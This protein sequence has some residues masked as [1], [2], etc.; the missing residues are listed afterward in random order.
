VAIYFAWSYYSSGVEV[1]KQLVAIRQQGQP[2]SLGELARRPAV[3]SKLDAQTYLAEVDFDLQSLEA[4]LRPLTK[5]LHAQPILDEK[6]TAAIEQIFSH[7][8]KVL[9]QLQ[10]ASMCENYYSRAD[11]SRSPSEFLE[12]LYKDLPR[13]KSVGRVLTANVK[14]LIAR[15]QFDQAAKQSL[16]IL[17]LAK[18]MDAEPTISA[19]GIAMAVRGLALSSL[20]DTMQS[21][22]IS[23]SVRLDIEKHLAA[24]N[25][26]LSF[27]AA[28]ISERA[29]GISKHSQLPSLIQ[30]TLLNE[31]LRCMELEIKNAELSYSEIGQLKATPTE[32][33]GVAMMI[34]LV[35]NAVELARE[36]TH[37]T[38]AI[39]R[40]LRILNAIQGD[41]ALK[42]AETIELSALPLP[43]DAIEDPFSFNAMLV[44]KSGDNWIVY[45]VGRDGKDDE[46]EIA[47]DKDL[48][49]FRR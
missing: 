33:S 15:G 34:E 40:A 25:L 21:G 24:D 39:N 18:H 46:G 28:L 1:E 16:V 6:T 12:S 49:T 44:R 43:A 42:N 35:K 4:E 30:P 11:F 5:N 32:R 10:L 7:Y 9:Q 23:A 3:D 37:R 14:V 20:S 19:Y 48:G 29:F 2:A 22:P 27:R 13:L 38:L 26:L 36:S 17:R 47:N 31:Y 8:P 45:S 41:I